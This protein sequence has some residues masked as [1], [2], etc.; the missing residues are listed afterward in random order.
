MIIFGEIPQILSKGDTHKS[1]P[2]S[3]L[4]WR[5][6]YY[7]TSIHTTGTC[8]SFY[9]VRDGV[10]GNAAI[11][12]SG[13]MHERYDLI[14]SNH[15]LNGHPRE[16]EI[17]RNQRKSVYRPYQMQPL[18]ESI[19]T[20]QASIFGESKY[21]LT[22]EDKEDNDYIWG[23]NFEGKT[24]VGYFEWMF[25]TI[26]EDPNS[27]FLVVPRKAGEET[28]TN[29]VEPHILHIPSRE[30]LY[31]SEDEI[32]FYEP[33]RYY[34]WYVNETGYFRYARDGKNWMLTNEDGYY[35]H[36]LGRRP[37]HF[38]GGIW[39]TH[40]YYDSYL[41]PALAFCDDFI[42]AHSSVQMVNK[43]A[44][45]PFIQAVSSDCPT[46]QGVGQRQYCNACK[47][48]SVD[49]TCGEAADLNLANCNKCNGT[50]QQSYN[51]ADWLVVPPD[52]AGTDLIRIINFDVNTNKFLAEYAD[53][54]LKGVKKALYQ[55]HIEEAQSGVA[56]DIDRQ[57]TYLYRAYVSNGVWQLI[58]QCLKDVL[59]IRN[60][61]GS[62]AYI[63]VKP[64]DFDLKTEQDLLEEYKESTDAKTPEYVRQWQIAQYL[65]KVAGG[66][67]L[68]KKKACLIN[69]MDAYSVTSI[70]DKLAMLSANG[71]TISEFTFS[72]N[73]PRILDEVIRSNGSTWFINSDYDTINTQVQ[74]VFEKME[75]PKTPVPINTEVKTIV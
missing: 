31:I 61:T 74:A 10:L 47:R 15:L 9:G 55:D 16:A 4:K 59:A 39:N 3:I 51:P 37:A 27:L 24:F 30:L 67:D 20:T 29:K 42:N 2:P 46:C 63:L 26:C 25:K 40:R 13:W 11:Y 69:Q 60:P 8:P 48:S 33:D 44:A 21:T 12:P 5:E 65:D 56:K 19:Q 22:V 64:T 43:E 41:K 54:I 66:D 72:N 45:H 52:K 50:G 6:I 57:A 36:L 62:N 53:G 17:T 14:F 70:V 34:A 49:C 32:L 1:M 23:D 18:L 38:A 71:I 73:L 7:R 75:L 28:D 68:M 35:A 58:E